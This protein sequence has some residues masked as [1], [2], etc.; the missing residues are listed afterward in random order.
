MKKKPK[1]FG[2]EIGNP[3]GDLS[4]ALGGH[5]FNDIKKGTNYLAWLTTGEISSPLFTD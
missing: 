3:M 1:A 2:E 5:I 4:V